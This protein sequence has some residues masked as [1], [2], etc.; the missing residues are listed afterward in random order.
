VLDA[1]LL[2]A[3]K[4]RKEPEPAGCDESRPHALTVAHTEN[5]KI[6]A[7]MK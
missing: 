6:L 5:R 7:V 4:L 1:A 2:A 3:G